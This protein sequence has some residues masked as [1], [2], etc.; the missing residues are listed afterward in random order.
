MRLSLTAQPPRRATLNARRQPHR[1]RSLEIARRNSR[2]CS[3]RTVR[4]CA[5]S[6]WVDRCLTGH[7][8]RSTFRNPE[9]F[10]QPRH[11]DALAV[12]GQKF[13]SAELLEH[14]DARG[15]GSL[16]SFFIR[17]FSPSISLSRFASL[18]FIPPYWDSQLMPR[19]LRDLKMTDTASS[20]S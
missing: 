20:R 15:P 17:S 3:S 16:T 19:R 11:G 8:T 5:A 9:P 18:A 4:T 12:R 6:R 1:V 2:S 7:R 10:T 14:V 13:P